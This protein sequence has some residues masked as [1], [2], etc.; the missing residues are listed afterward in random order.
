MI[1]IEFEKPNITTC[2]CCG[3]KTVR[4]TRFVYQ[5]DDAFAVYYILFTDGHE[6]KVVEGLIG[7]GEWGEEGEAE[8]RTAFAFRIWTIDDEY[9]VG[10]MDANESPW[11]DVNFLGSILDREDA[12]KHAWIKDVFHITDHIVLEDEDVIDYFNS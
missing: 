6:D 2:E 1:K 10:L 9:Q 5:D 11:S 3:G 4:L 7:L 12:L 8:D